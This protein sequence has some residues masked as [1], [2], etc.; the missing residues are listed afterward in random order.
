MEISQDRRIT[1]WKRWHNKICV[2]KVA[3]DTRKPVLL[4]RVIQRLIPIEVRSDEATIMDEGEEEQNETAT[5]NEEKLNHR[6]RRTTAIAGEARRR[7]S[8][9]K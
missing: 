6:P 2:V 8:N 7:S 3:N 5:G 1:T 4:K 9:M